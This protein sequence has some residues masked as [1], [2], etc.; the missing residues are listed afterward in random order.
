M[1]VRVLSV[2]SNTLYSTDRLRVG[3]GER[4][5]GE[6]SVT[7]TSHPTL[8][9]V[10]YRIRRHFFLSLSRSPPNDGASVE[11]GKEEKGHERR[12]AAV[13]VCTAP[14]DSE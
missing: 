1:S 8:E 4:E 11:E 2:R 13:Y 3:G 12:K 7:V 14:R 10:K 6:E 9:E 5:D